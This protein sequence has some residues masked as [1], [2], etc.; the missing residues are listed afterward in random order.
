MPSCL[1]SSKVDAGQG[2][3]KWAVGRNRTGSSESACGEHRAEP[4]HFIIQAERGPSEC[5]RRVEG[6]IMRTGR[7][8]RGDGLAASR[9]VMQPWRIYLRLARLIRSLTPA[10][11]LALS[12]EQ[13]LRSAITGTSY[14]SRNLLTGDWESRVCQVSLSRLCLFTGLPKYLES[15]QS[16]QGFMLMLVT[17]DHVNPLCR[18]RDPPSQGSLTN[19]AAHLIAD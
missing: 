13:P 9:C 1:L 8:I 5:K 2:S 15:E 18:Q 6:K 14:L 19:G 17:S 11:T 3:A 7:G 12:M 16:S 10:I 4:D